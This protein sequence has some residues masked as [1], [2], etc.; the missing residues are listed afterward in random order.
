MGAPGRVPAATVDHT[1]L[2]GN[3]SRKSWEFFD[4][5]V[6]V[7]RLQPFDD[8]TDLIAKRLDLGIAQVGATHL[9]QVDDIL[10]TEAIGHGV[11]FSR[12]GCWSW[13][14]VISNRES[15]CRP[16]LRRSSIAAHDSC[17]GWQRGLGGQSE[18]WAIRSLSIRRLVAFITGDSGG[19]T[20]GLTDRSSRS[21]HSAIDRKS[22]TVALTGK[23]HDLWVA[24]AILMLALPRYKGSFMPLYPQK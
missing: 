23:Q 7:Q 9:S 14:E 3:R 18:R 12:G 21:G 6:V 19:R 4:V 5:G 22:A 16:A 8:R 15:G 10:S 13:V 20:V 24:G 11:G 1:R 2:S 17:M